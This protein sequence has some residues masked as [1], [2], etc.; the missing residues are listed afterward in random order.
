MSSPAL[1]PLILA[2]ICILLTFGCYMLFMRLMRTQSRL[3]LAEKELAVAQA[4]NHDVQLSEMKEKLEHYENDI[5]S[6]TANIAKLDSEKSAL[7]EKIADQQLYVQK[8]Q[9]QFQLQ[10]ENLAH[11]IFEEKNLQS[12]QSLQELLNPLKEE[13]GG[14]KKHVTESFGEHAK[15]QFALKKEIE[16]FVKVSGDMRFQ[17]ESLSKAL[18][19]DAKTQG[20]WGEVI[21]ERILEA[22]GLR[23][24]EEYITQGTGMGL[25]HPED[26]RAQKP[27]I[28]IQLPEGRHAIIDAKVSLTAFERFC[29]ES[30][31]AAK[32]VQLQLFL[33]S[34]RAHAKGLE[35]RR[36]QDTQGLNT[37]DYVMMFMPI[38]GA[39]ALA[40][41]HD[42]DLHAHAWER[43]VIIVC[44]STLFAILKIIA[45]MWKIERQNKNAEAIAERGGK[46][47]DKIVG[48]M[49]DMKAMGKALETAQ[50][51]YDAAFSK[52][53]TG[54]GNILR[55]T[56]QLSELGAK[57]SKKL[58]RELL[59]DEVRLEAPKDAA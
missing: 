42:P 47:Y 13:L 16:T 26:G 25:K 9:E 48:F 14:F 38:E 1:I 12:K 55:Q 54:A 10:F 34:V 21:L 27:D 28:I 22:A 40:M 18:K 32:G 43:K 20:N 11:K 33:Q 58:S 29:S 51:K 57:H 6:Y 15:E 8:V 17:T 2:G 31:D 24:G 3:L 44:P 19:G 52:L 46:L 4:G 23:R 49:E 50:G 39:Y 59:D 53:S 30:D 45:S 37:P 7:H 36:Y 41:Q 35:D 5:R 56:E